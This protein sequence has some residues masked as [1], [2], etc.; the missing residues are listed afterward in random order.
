MCSGGLFFLISAQNLDCVILQTP[1]L[2]KLITL[3]GLDILSVWKKL[4][5]AVFLL[6]FLLVV[7]VDFR[8]RF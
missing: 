1:P 4:N 7:F 6:C 2:V 5:L 8:F 3:K